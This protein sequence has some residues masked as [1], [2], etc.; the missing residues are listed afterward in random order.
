MLD[1]LETC[2][3]AALWSKGGLGMSHRLGHFEYNFIIGVLLD[4]L[5]HHSGGCGRVSGVYFLGLKGPALVSF[6][7][8]FFFKKKEKDF[9]EML[10]NNKGPF[11]AM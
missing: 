7:V 4:Y 1:F 11:I 2:R 10:Y 8:I 9:L 6:N 3:G 5:I